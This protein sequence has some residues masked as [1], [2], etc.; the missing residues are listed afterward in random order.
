VVFLPAIRLSGGE[1]SGPASNRLAANKANSLQTLADVDRWKFHA[2]KP[3]DV[4][5]DQHGNLHGTFV[6]QNGHPQAGRLVVARQNPMQ[7]RTAQTDA[8]GA[9]KFSRLRGGNWS[10]IVG[11]QTSLLRVWKFGI[12]PPTAKSNVL[13]VRNATVV[14]GQSIVEPGIMTAFD[15]GALL[16]AGTGLA[17][18]TL[19]AVGVSEASESTNDTGPAPSSVSMANSATTAGRASPTLANHE[20]ETTQSLSVLMFDEST[21]LRDQ[22][23]VLRNAD[24]TQDFTFDSQYGQPVIFNPTLDSIVTAPLDRLSSS[25]N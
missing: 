13:L 15:N 7:V 17:G 21:I 4:M 9:F 1:L 12:A 19:A 16:S 20:P 22:L 25:A 5:L 10:V 3:S 23:N 18:L 2:P 8:S 6:D 11:S 14:R 24:G